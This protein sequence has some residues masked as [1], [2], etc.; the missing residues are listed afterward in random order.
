MTFGKKLYSSHLLDS[1]YMILV[2]LLVTRFKG[3]K[4]RSVSSDYRAE[5][6]LMYKIVKNQNVDHFINKS[7]NKNLTNLNLQLK[8]Y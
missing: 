8:M 5:L 6:Y 1:V 2:Y 3:I 7:M 4:F